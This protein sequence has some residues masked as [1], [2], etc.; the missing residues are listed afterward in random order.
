M[1]GVHGL[2][3]ITFGLSIGVWTGLTSHFIIR[4]NLA[5]HLEKI[6]QWIDSKNNIFS[7]PNQFS[8]CF[9]ATLA[10]LT[11]TLFMGVSVI[12]SFQNAKTIEMNNPKYKMYQANLKTQCGVSNLNEELNYK[13]I[14]GAS[15]MV[16]PWTVY[17]CI[18]LKGKQ[19]FWVVDEHFSSGI[20]NGIKKCV[21]FSVVLSIA[22]VPIHYIQ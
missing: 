3:Q 6:R 15:L 1:V 5:K 19:S 21:A 13:C 8:P 18:L 11:Y 4:D 22:F 20:V 10:I 17:L 14:K 16:F 9:P 2:D 12:I 7:Q